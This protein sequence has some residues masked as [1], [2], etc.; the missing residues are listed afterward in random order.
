M[1]GLPSPLSRSSSRFF[2]SVQTHVRLS[3]TLHHNPML[4][5]LL[6]HLPKLLQLWTL[7]PPGPSVHGIFQA[8]ILK[9]AA[10]SFFRESYRPRD[11][12][13]V[14][15]IGRQILYH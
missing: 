15:C 5:H 1:I 12:T 7:G 8:R 6:I 10:I 11:Q 14:S 9:W 2:L 13:R 3:Y 4:Y